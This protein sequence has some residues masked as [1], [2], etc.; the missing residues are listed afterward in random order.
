MRLVDFPHHLWFFYHRHLGPQYLSQ[1]STPREGSPRMTEIWTI[2][3]NFSLAV[4]GTALCP[5]RMFSMLLG[6][7][8]IEGASKATKSHSP[9]EPPFHALG[10]LS[11]FNS[12][13]QELST[14]QG[15]PRNCLPPLLRAGSWGLSYIT[16]PTP[17]KALRPSFLNGA[18]TPWPNLLS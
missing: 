10:W 3:S 17:L 14:T 1:D 16:P 7:Q 12:R 18:S 6:V 11:P 9:Q 13:N 5:A 15:S 8:V 4:H 2:S